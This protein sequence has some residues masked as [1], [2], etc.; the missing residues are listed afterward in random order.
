MLLGMK[1]VTVTT[2]SRLHST[3]RR[4]LLSA[5]K[6]EIRQTSE[7]LAYSSA[8]ISKLNVKLENLRRNTAQVL[9]LSKD[10]SNSEMFETTTPVVCAHKLLETDENVNVL[11]SQLSNPTSK[12]DLFDEVAKTEHDSPASST[13]APASGTFTV[14][15]LKKAR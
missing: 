14:K 8:Q 11:V 9:Q 5:A 12:G 7:E 2:D 4:V 10:V 1:S 3:L 6:D 13:S 15:E